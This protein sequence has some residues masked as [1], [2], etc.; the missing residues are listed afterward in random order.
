MLTHCVVQGAMRD[1]YPEPDHNATRWEGLVAALVPLCHIT[2]PTAH[3]PDTSHIS[4]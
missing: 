1:L 4:K 3:L 2:Q